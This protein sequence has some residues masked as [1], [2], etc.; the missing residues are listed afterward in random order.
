M[1]IFPPEILRYYF[2]NHSFHSGAE[3]EHCMQVQMSWWQSEKKGSADNTETG[4]RQ[5]ES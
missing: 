5:E 4:F 3:K 2:T 1:F